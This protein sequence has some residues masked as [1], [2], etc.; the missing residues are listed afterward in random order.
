MNCCVDHKLSQNYERF[1]SFKSKLRGTDVTVEDGLM[2][3]G[4]VTI[5]PASKDRSLCQTC[6]LMLG[7]VVKARKYVNDLEEQYNNRTSESGYFSIK[8]KYADRSPKSTP[9]KIKVFYRLC[10]ARITIMEIIIKSY[11]Y[12]NMSFWWQLLQVGFLKDIID[13]VHVLFC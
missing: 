4:N 7:K 6:Y 8:R 1:H 9:R 2:T 12:F 5:T 3:I 11:L 10:R 13:T